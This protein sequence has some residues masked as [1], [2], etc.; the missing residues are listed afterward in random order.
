MFQFF[1]DS[2]FFI[3]SRVEGEHGLLVAAEH[4]RGRWEAGGEHVQPGQ[5]ERGADQPAAGHRQRP[6]FSIFGKKNYFIY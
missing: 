3:F 1:F 2:N 6:D 4:Q 5:V